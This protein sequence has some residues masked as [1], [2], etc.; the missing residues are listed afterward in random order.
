MGRPGIGH[1]SR[2][3][4][5][6]PYFEK[7][8]IW[9]FQHDFEVLSIR[10]GAQTARAHLIFIFSSLKLKSGG[11]VNNEAPSRIPKNPNKI[12]AALPLLHPINPS[13]NPINPSPK[14]VRPTIAGGPE[15]EKDRMRK[16]RGLL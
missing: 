6:P 12:A 3:T 11:S 1:L 16:I 4:T 15:K 8:R 9:R 14:N 7:S 5:P 10:K 13:R 2:N